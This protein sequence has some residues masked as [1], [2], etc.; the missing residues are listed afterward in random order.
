MIKI[1]KDISSFSK[2]SC[3]PTSKRELVILI[4]NRISKEGN[5]CDLNDIDTSLITDMSWL[6]SCTDFNGDIS[7]WDVSNV[8]KMS[9]MFN[10]SIFNNDISKWD[11]IKVKDMTRMFKY[12]SFDQD[13]SNWNIRQ[14][15][16]TDHMFNKCPINDKHKPNLLK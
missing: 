2:H 3:R 6:F 7:D 16:D 1:G 4:N 14:D 11:V 10:R 13:I 9:Y 5:N 12:S 15:C 8:E